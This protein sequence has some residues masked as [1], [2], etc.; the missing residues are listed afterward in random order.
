MIVELKQELDESEKSSSRKFNKIDLTDTYP[1]YPTEIMKFS[2]Q[3]DK[4]SAENKLNYNVKLGN[5]SERWAFSRSA[6]LPVQE[7]ST[8]VSE[9]TIIQSKSQI[10][11]LDLPSNKEE[12]NKSSTPEP[13]TNFFSLRQALEEKLYTLSNE[14]QK[15]TQE[16]SRIPSTAPKSRQRISEIEQSLDFLDSSISATKR[17]MRE[18]GMI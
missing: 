16:L 12:E 1:D 9:A 14:K 15:L 6:N 11:A 17:R 4:N 10:S 18:L 2:K 13:T 8:A 3:E 7:N 5:H